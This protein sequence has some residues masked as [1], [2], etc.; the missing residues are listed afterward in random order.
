M[1]SHCLQ[2]EE[3]LPYAGIPRSANVKKE[4]LPSIRRSLI[5]QWKIFRLWGKEKFLQKRLGKPAREGRLL[6]SGT[7]PLSS[8]HSGTKLE[9]LRFLRASTDGLTLPSKR[10]TPPSAGMLRSANVKKKIL[11]TIWKSLIFPWKIFGFQE[12]EEFLQKGLG[13]PAREGRLLFFSGI[14]TYSKARAVLL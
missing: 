14:P 12:K 9:A 4:I 3:L 5:F 2:K 11:P 8:A 7:L 13:K 10:S 1:A 6:F